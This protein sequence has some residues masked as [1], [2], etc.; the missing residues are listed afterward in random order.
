MSD[1][2]EHPD[3]DEFGFELYWPRRARGDS[4]PVSAPADEL[5]PGPDPEPLPD[6]D[7]PRPR[8]VE[9]APA[10]EEPRPQVVE[11]PPLVEPPPRFSPDGSDPRALIREFQDQLE[12]L[13]ERQLT[14]LDDEIE[15]R[16]DKLDETIGAHHAQMSSLVRNLQGWQSDLE[17]LVSAQTQQFERLMVACQRELN[18]SVEAHIGEIQRAIAQGADEINR[19]ADRRRQGID[20]A[21]DDRIGEVRREVTRTLAEFER[22]TQPVSW[23]RP[24]STTGESGLSR[25]SGAGPAFDEGAPADAVD[26]VAEGPTPRAEQ[27][28]TSEA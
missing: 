26:R 27:G 13:V 19:L 6:F 1:V 7:D 17:G 12:R 3:D 8:A 2:P 5:A 4:A 24:A 15:T 11:E 28:P 23:E 14:Y 21:V 10:E 9:T 20:Q 25:G 18:K 16:S 22:S